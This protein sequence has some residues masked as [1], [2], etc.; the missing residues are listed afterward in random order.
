MLANNTAHER[1][2]HN[3]PDATDITFIHVMNGTN[4]PVANDVP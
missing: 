4:Y 1:V 3:Y 2:R